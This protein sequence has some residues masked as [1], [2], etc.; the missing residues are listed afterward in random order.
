VSTVCLPFGWLPVS[1]PKSVLVSGYLGIALSGSFR[2]PRDVPAVKLIHLRFTLSRQ[3]L[4]LRPP[5]PT[6]DRTSV[7]LCRAVVSTHLDVAVE[8]LEF[9]VFAM[10]LFTSAIDFNSETLFFTSEMFVEDEVDLTSLL[11]VIEEL[12]LCCVSNCRLDKPRAALPETVLLG[13][14]KS[15]LPCPCPYFSAGALLSLLK[16]AFF[17]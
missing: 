11:C 4:P 16:R 8:L 1:E 5:P 7:L 13:G 3:V 9:V 17:C 6:T 15:R 2:V 10:E 14:S 12:V